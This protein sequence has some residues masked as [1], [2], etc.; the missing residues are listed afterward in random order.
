MSGAVT[1]DLNLLREAAAGDEPLGW[2]MALDLVRG[3][4]FEGLEQASWPV[5]EGLLAEAE[6]LVAELA[7]RA[8]DRSLDRGELSMAISA[9]R[10]GVLAAPFDERLYRSWMVV[11]DASGNPAGVEAAMR[12]LAGT[13]GAPMAEL[14]QVVHPMTWATYRRLALPATRAN[15]AV[16][17]NL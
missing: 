15:E 11:A 16:V 5:A 7:L 17:A 8:A 14:E 12:A 9:V 1:C 4:P 10:S 3:R 2:W 13:L 6:E